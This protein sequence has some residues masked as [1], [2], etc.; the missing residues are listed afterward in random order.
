M[1]LSINTFFGNHKG[2]RVVQ[3]DILLPPV[4]HCG[5]M[6]NKRDISSHGIRNLLT[7]DFALVYLAYFLFA[8]A[9]QS[10]VPTMPIFLSNSGSNEREIGLLIGVFAIASL[11]FR[12]VAGGVI[13]KYSEKNV[14][15]VGALLSVLAFLALSVFRPFWPIFVVRI[16]QGIAFAFLSTAAFTYSLSIIPPVY[17]TRGIAYYMIAPNIA[18]AIAAPLGMFLI[19]QYSFNVLFLFGAALSLC[20]CFFPWTVRKREKPVIEKRTL[21][22]GNH[23]FEWKI[24]VPAF[25]GFLHTFIFGGISAFF[26]LYAIECGVKNPGH[27]FSAT[28]FAIIASRILGGRFLDTYNKEKIILMFISLSIAAMVIVAF[29][30]TLPMFILAGLL[31][32]IGV[33]FVNPAMMAY[34]FEY[35]GSSSGTAVGTF[36]ALMD[37]GIA[38]GPLAMGLILPVTGYRVMFM[39]LAFVYVISLC[40]FQ[41]YVRK[42]RHLHSAR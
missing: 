16:F 18:T 6:N 9:N 28:A 13:S 12:L 29:S 15:I 32:G 14:M 36:Q 2:L 22:P 26:P 11:A 21:E 40:Y 7:R 24:V 17:R 30:K 41:F 4:K 37:F 33:A 35:T 1:W 20:S 39:C 5:A 42:R 10:L 38:I 3:I 23:L 25:T 8:V 27:F 34:S 31:Q 19:N